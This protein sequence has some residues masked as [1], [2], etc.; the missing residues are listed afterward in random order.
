MLDT[1]AIRTLRGRLLSAALALTA[2]AFAGGWRSSIAVAIAHQPA[3]TVLA[4]SDG[5][6]ELGKAPVWVALADAESGKPLTATTL[7]AWIARQ[8]EIAL[9]VNDISAM[10]PPGSAF[11]V[12]LGLSPTTVPE[13]RDPHLV[14]RISF[15]NEVDAGPRKAAPSFRNYD[16]TPLLQ[17]LAS[18]SLTGPIGVTIVPER[19]PS[20]DARPTVGNIQ[21]VRP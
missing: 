2:A 15:Y 8:R 18:S 9:I 7:R 10:A 3:M 14:G 6:I 21:I 12:Y 16:I 4:K 13:K 5:P 20:P 11:G 17:R 1:A 19:A